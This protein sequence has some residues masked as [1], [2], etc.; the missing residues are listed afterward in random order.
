MI[1]LIDDVPPG[2]TGIRLSGQVSREEYQQTVLPA[3]RDRLEAGETVRALLVIDAGFERFEPGAIWEDVKFGVGTGLG[4]LSKWER[5]ALVAD[6]SWAHHAI[7]L[8]G[9]MVPGDVEVFGL[10]QLDEAKAWVAA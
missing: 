1:E 4:H 9:W 3:F 8:F 5:T 2:V 7:A 6:A 10:E